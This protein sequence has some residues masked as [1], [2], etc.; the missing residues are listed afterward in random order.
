MTLSTFLLT[1]IPAPTFSLTLLSGMSLSVK[2]KG[3]ES[4]LPGVG[5]RLAGHGGLTPLPPYLPRTH[6]EMELLAGSLPTSQEVFDPAPLESQPKPTV[7]AREKGQG[8]IQWWNVD[9]A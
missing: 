1:V 2:A 7:M 9:S 3:W 8:I 4:I 5:C 6:L